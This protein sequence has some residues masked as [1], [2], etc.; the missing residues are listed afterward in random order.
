MSVSDQEVRSEI[1]EARESL[2]AIRASMRTGMVVRFLG[3]VAGIIIVLIYVFSFWGLVRGVAESGQIEQQLRE[4]VPLV[5]LR[6]GVRQIIREAGPVYM[7]EV[8]QILS[9]M[10]LTEMLNVQLEA[11]YQDLRPVLMEEFSR[12]RPR[13]AAAVRGELQASA[14][15][16]E[17]ELQQMVESRLAQIIR[18]RQASLAAEADV[19]EED[20]EKFL[21]NMIDANQQALM[22]VIDRRWA[23]NTEELE[24]IR[25]T[26]EQFPEMPEMSDEALLEHTVRV[27]VALMKYK[28][29]DYEFTPATDIPPAGQEAQAAPPQVQVDL[30]K[31]PEEHRD[32]VEEAIEKAR[33]AAQDAQQAAP[34][35]IEI[36]LSR[37]PEEH[38]EEVE[39]SLKD[40]GV[41]E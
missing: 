13:L 22:S 36:D 3:L 24:E 12:V 39:Q 16:L 38:R 35:Q 6:Q 11:A 40:A 10:G 9:E 29:E 18:D 4:R 28:L 37:V 41:T 31:V 23:D 30:S 25:Q 5:G 32:Q 14:D 2:Q 26:A 27:L 17:A 21:V 19:S 33:Q 20:V 1:A 15:Q 8:E 7:K 34:P